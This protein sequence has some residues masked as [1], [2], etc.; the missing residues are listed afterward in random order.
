MKLPLT[1]L[2]LGVAL[3]LG[4]C[5]HD[6][7]EAPSP[8]VPEPPPQTPELPLQTPLQAG[9]APIVALG[10]AIHVGT[11]VAPP[12]D[13]LSEAAIHGDARVSHGSV[14]DGIG[15]AELIAYLAADSTPPE[16]GEEGGM[17]AVTILEVP[18]IRFRADPPAHPGRGLARCLNGN[19]PQPRGD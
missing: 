13:V 9:Q 7:E 5:V 8:G 4:A 18:L 1:F 14:Q 10:D 3:T 19:P 6:S 17:P 12:A 11:D 16:T 2:G 15:A